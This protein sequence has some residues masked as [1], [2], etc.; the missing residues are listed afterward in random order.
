MDIVRAV[1]TWGSLVKFSHSVFAL[2]FALSMALFVTH[3]QA[4]E[5]LKF[6]WIILALVAARSAAMTFNRIVDRHFDAL[7]PRTRAREIPSG[8]IDLRSAQIF[9]FL[10]AL[11]FVLSA[12]ALG[13]HCLVLSPVVLGV[14]L[15]YS[16][17]K[18]FTSYS[19]LVLGVSLAL[20]PGGVWYA[21]TA[22]FAW[23]PVP[24]MCAVMFWV[25][26]FDILYACQDREFDKEHALYSMP[27][28]LGAKGAFMA[29][30]VLHLLAVVCLVWFGLLAE[31]GAIYFVGVSIFAWL[32]LNQH[33]IVRPD[34]LSRLDAAFFTRNGVASII[35]FIFMWLEHFGI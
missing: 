15:L 34:D 10:S 28:R 4:V 12:A 25:A 24:L 3:R 27:V 29:A 19:H 11:V 35:F 32:L 18:R 9:L 1:Q 23:L 14:L 31:L 2:P 20:A 30:R 33:S 16:V 8:R 6:A 22:E 26:G 7:N 17:T 21:L 13:M 5:P